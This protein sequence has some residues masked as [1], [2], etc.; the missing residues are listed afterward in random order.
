MPTDNRSPD[1]IE[2]DIERERADLAGTIDELQARFTPEAVVREI[3]RY[4]GE[5]GGDMRHA[6][7]RSAKQNPLGLALTGVGLA[8]L[9]FGRSYD[10]VDH[11]RARRHDRLDDRTDGYGG[12]GSGGG[13][14]TGSL[15]PARRGGYEPD[16]MV[17]DEEEDDSVLYGYPADQQ[18]WMD[19]ASD[20]RS[21]T[22]SRMKSGA[23][24]AAHRAHE[25]GRSAAS[26]VSGA[27]H[28]AASRVS[29][30]G[31]GAASR[32]S[33]AAHRARQG[34]SDGA[35]AVS[36]RAARMRERLSHGTED[37]SEAARARV[38]AARHRAVSARRKAAAATRSGWRQGRDTA[39][40][41][42][43]DHPLVVGALAIA[44]GAAIAAALPKTRVEEEWLGD[45]SD[46][47]MDEAERI[48]LEEREKAGKIASAAV[49]EAAD[50][51]DE[52]RD[53]VEGAARDAVEGARREATE[54]GQRIA[55]AA[56][57]EA[58][59]QTSDK[60]DK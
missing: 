57:E 58:E 26:R 40:D 32:A 50:I 41:L 1:E 2:R 21:G 47:L 60:S 12:I 6:V 42:F 44:A 37:L 14:Y 25:A 45:T 19:E 55:S 53:K 20:S 34:L 28:S 23:S 46:E 24:D 33:D 59:R 29:D 52:K 38:M 48:F 30:A 5:H 9:M 4:F 10:P 8:W 39:V 15:P 31:H 49:G 54:A 16:W 51:V 27:G 7:S 18:A 36:E 13:S 22:G 35:G 56:G 11:Y 3:T 43:E 17:I